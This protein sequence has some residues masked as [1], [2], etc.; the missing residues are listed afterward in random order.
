MT[1]SA[2]KAEILKLEPNNR[3]A[4][5]TRTSYGQMAAEY[6]CVKVRSKNRPDGVTMEPA[7]VKYM[8]EKV[9]FSYR[10]EGEDFLGDYTYTPVALPEI[11]YWFID[12]GTTFEVVEHLPGL[13]IRAGDLDKRES[14]DPRRIYTVKAGNE[15]VFKRIDSATGKPVLWSYRQS[16]EI[17]VSPL[18]ELTPTE[19]YAK[20]SASGHKTMTQKVFAA[21]AISRSPDITGKELTALLMETFPNHNVTTRHGPHY[22]SLSKNGRLP[23]APDDDPRLWGKDQG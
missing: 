22:L 8:S 3:V 4:V 15:V 1:R 7:T 12:D 10:I 21:W 13:T 5:D 6:E 19:S 9:G 2:L 17:I 23:E 16:M 18:M 11:G 20:A 14:F